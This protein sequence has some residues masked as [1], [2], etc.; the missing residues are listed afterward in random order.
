MRHTGSERGNV[1]QTI[2]LFFA[3][4]ALGF[5]P[6]CGPD[7]V[8]GRMQALSAPGLHTARPYC[9]EVAANGEG[10]GQNFEHQGSR[11]RK[12]NES[13]ATNAPPEFWCGVEPACAEI[14]SGGYGDT[15]MVQGRSYRKIDEDWSNESGD[16][17]CRVAG[18]EP[19][20]ASLEAYRVPDWYRDAKFGIFMHWGIHSATEY[21]AWYGR[22]MYQQ[23]D[24]DGAYCYAYHSRTHGHPSEFGF[25]D[26]IPRWTGERWDPDGLVEF[27]KRIGARYVVPVALYHDNFDNFRSSH[28]PWNSL[29]LGP[30]KDVVGEW[31]R[32][33]EK[34][35]LRLGVSDH[36]S[37]AWQW[38]AVAHGSDTSGPLQGIPYDGRLTRADGLGKWWEGYDPQDLYLRPHRESDPAPEDF[39]QNWTLRVLELIDAYQPDLLYFDWGTLPHEGHGLQIAA[40]FYNQSAEKNQGKPEVVI[41]VKGPPSPYA[42]VHDVEKGSFSD[43]KDFAWQ[44]DTTLNHDWFYIK[45]APL[46]FSGPELIH[47]LV[48]IV[49]K[50]GNLLL[51]V[52]LKPDGTLPDDQ[53]E[54]LLEIGQWLTQNGEA[55]YG[56]RPF[57]IFGEGPTNVD[58]QG[59]GHFS[60]KPLVYTKEDLRFTTRPGTIYAISMARPESPLAIKS[61]GTHTGLVAG[62]IQSVR[63]LG[64]PRDLGFSRTERALT[65]ELPQPLPGQNAWVLAIRL[66][67]R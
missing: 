38:M 36:A 47:K 45:G 37:R 55:I 15:F 44:T 26:F 62:G 60:E 65:V 6:S 8:T 32:A 34:H 52:G 11:Y 16:N 14:Y 13:W 56:T 22:K 50:N 2:A 4:A 48:D 59:D 46:H 66:D 17:W 67:P 18:F 57:G 23:E 31:K 9:R 49:S 40:H 51:N 28:Q 54:A 64:H 61:L 19:T 12:T 41:T 24:P 33:C 20:W 35:G 5:A 29:N 43:Q 42:V 53:R 1:L 27:Y 10:Y 39:K 25:K 7:E 30:R 21:D 63:L 3:I 58:D